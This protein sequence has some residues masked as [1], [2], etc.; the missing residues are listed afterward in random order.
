ME[1]DAEDVEGFESFIERYKA[2][3]PIEANYQY[4]ETVSHFPYIRVCDK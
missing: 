4:D 3:L 1:P 2:G